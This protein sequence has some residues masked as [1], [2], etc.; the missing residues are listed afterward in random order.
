LAAL[1]ATALLLGRGRPAAG[2]GGPERPGLAS[3]PAEDAAYAVEAVPAGDAWA[4]GGFGGPGSAADGTT[5]P[6]AAAGQPVASPERRA[7]ARRAGPRRAEPPAAPPRPS[8]R[9]IGPTAAEPSAPR[10]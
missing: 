3:T 4:T 7:R 5:G 10:T 1:A 6:L 8:Y 9:V 2:S